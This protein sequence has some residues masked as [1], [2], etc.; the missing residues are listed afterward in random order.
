[1]DHNKYIEEWL[2]KK[3]NLHNWSAWSLFVCVCDL[4]YF[5]LRFSWLCVSRVPFTRIAEVCNKSLWY[6]MFN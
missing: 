5:C 6:S 2:V 3:S 1:M 4:D